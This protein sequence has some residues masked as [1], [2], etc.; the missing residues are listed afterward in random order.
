MLEVYCLRLL[1]KIVIELYK[2]MKNMYFL[3]YIMMVF[4]I[5]I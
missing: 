2:N 5:H 1:N 4:I 3:R